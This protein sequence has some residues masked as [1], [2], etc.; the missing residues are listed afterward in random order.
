M[1]KPTCI[2][3]LGKPTDKIFFYAVKHELLMLLLTVLIYVAVAKGIANYAR[4]KGN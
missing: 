4:N 1:N 3:H 2:V